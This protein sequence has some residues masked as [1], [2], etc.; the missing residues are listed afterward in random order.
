MSRAV[1]GTLRS[2]WPLKP[3]SSRNA[4][5]LSVRSPW[6]PSRSR[7]SW[8]GC[9]SG[10]AVE[11]GDD[12][13]ARQLRE[14]LGPRRLRGHA[15]AAD[16]R[17]ARAL[18]AQVLPRRVRERRL[19]LHRVR[20]GGRAPQRRGQRP[21]PRAG[22]GAHARVR[23]REGR[24]RAPRGRRRRSTGAPSLVFPG[25]EEGVRLT[26]AHA[27]RRSAHRSSRSTARCL[28]EG[29]AGTRSSPLGEVGS[30]IA[31]QMAETEDPAERRALYAR[32]FAGDTLVGHDAASSGRSSAKLEGKPG[33]TLR[34]GARTLASSEPVKAKAVRSTIDTRIQAAAV[35]ALAGPA[36]RHRGHR[37]AHGPGARARGNRVLG[38]PA[39]RVGVQD[40]DHGRGARG[41]E[42]EA[43]RR[44]RGRVARADR[45]GDARERQRRAVRRHLRP[46]LRQ[47]VQLGVRAARGEGR[48]PRSWSRPPS[49]SAG[50]RSPGSRA[51]RRARCPTPAGSSPRWRSG[52]RRSVS[53]RCWRPRFRWRPSRRPSRTTA[54][55]WRRRS[56][57]RAPRAAS[58]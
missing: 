10:S 11:G 31:G 56:S 19:D 24:R 21:R 6:P 7:R 47:V 55:A 8:P 53:S 9:W 44:V 25:L 33:G 38:P 52:R 16:R 28:R 49:G 43:L 50:T 26:P 18:P 40:R 57:R 58:A 14:G 36:R 4:A 15:R 2:V 34:A 29:P 13:A 5:S 23:P 41:E 20:C 51:R 45:R 42:G 32:G 46:E 27:R 12:R 22:H 3:R 17:R 35:T 1:E 37:H 30:S 48:A 39:A 54:C